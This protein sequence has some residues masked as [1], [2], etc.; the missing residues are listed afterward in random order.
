MAEEATANQNQLP[1]FEIKKVYLKDVSFESPLSPE[2][3][4]Q[5]Y[6]PALSVDFGLENK[7]LDVEPDTYSSTIRITAT[8]KD[9]EDENKTYFVA[10]V[11]Y[12]GVFTI[13]LEEEIQRRHA[14]EAV[15]PTVMFPYASERICSLVTTGGFPP[16]I[17][18]PVNFEVLFAQKLE[19]ERQKQEGQPQ[20]GQQPANG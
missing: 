15:C 2:V 14:L 20:E 18:P 8:C 11:K 6:K 7:K 16:V 4:T 13:R 9:A 3:F 10:E 17:L 1:P 12:A 5:Q 19:S